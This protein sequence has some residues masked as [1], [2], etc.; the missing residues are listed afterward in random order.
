MTSFD[1]VIVGGGPAGSTCARALKQAGF[2]ALVLDKSNFPRDKVCAGWI[3]P[4]VVET[5]QLDLSEYR[6]NRTLQPITAFV[7]GLGKD[8]ANDVAYNHTVSYGIRRC[9]FDEYLLRRSGAQLKL[10]ESFQTIE[11]RGS[12]WILNGAIRT[13]LLIGAGGH[14]CPVAQHL[15]ASVGRDEPAI[16]AQEI[17]FEMNAEQANSCTTAPQTPELY[18]C[19]DLKG[20]AWC[21]RKGNFLNVGLGRDDNHGLHEQ[22][23]AFW[24]WLATQGKVPS[25]VRPRFKGHAYLLHTRSPRKIVDDGVLLIG[26]AVGL[27]YP[28]SGEGIRPA[29]ESGIM[30]AEV[31]VAARPNYTLSALAN[32]ETKLQARFGVRHASP[33]MIPA[34]IKV[35]LAR[36]LMKTRWFARKVVIGRWFLHSQQPALT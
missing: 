4:Q 30:A 18:F 22:L 1:A 23:K 19:D 17:E 10:G 3:T 24:D 33:S 21:F 5:L 13:P 8:I 7:A 35:K 26:D 15:G 9:E 20:Y 14:F 36:S 27:A 2:N 6:Q 25:D 28:E 11:R 29:I 32:Y 12:E 31:I 16:T 34:A